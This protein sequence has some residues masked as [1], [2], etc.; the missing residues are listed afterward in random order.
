MLSTNKLSNASLRRRKRRGAERLLRKKPKRK[1]PSSLPDGQRLKPPANANGSYSYNWRASMRRIRPQT[2]RARKTSLHRTLLR[3]LARSYRARLHP[4]LHHLRHLC[5]QQL[6][7]CR[8]KRALHHRPWRVLQPLLSPV[9]TLVWGTPKPKTHSSRRWLCLFRNLT[10]CQRL[11]LRQATPARCQ[12][13][14]SI[15]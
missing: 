11:R 6:R 12:R 14:P 9:L 13:T 7:R 15:V 5:R 10:P 1:K 2:T 8:A 3:L 4:R